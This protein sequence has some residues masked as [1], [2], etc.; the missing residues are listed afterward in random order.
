VPSPFDVIVVGGGIAGLAAAFELQQHGLRVRVF[1]ASDRPGGVIL[2]ERFDGW[3]VDGGP[4]ALL[5]QKPA[6]VAL[7]RE[8]GLGERLHATQTP[9][10]AYV[11]R[12]GRLYP[13]A[14]GSF[15]GFP[16]SA[17]ALARSSL[18]STR[19]KLRMGFEVFVPRRASTTDESIG[20]FVRRRFGQEATDYLADPL[21]AGIH[22]GDKDRLSIQALFPRLVEAERRV[23]SVIR[24]FRDLRVKPSPNGAFVSLPGGI[25]EMVDR[26]VAALTPGTL[27][28]S[29]P[30][31]AIRGGKTF[32]VEAATHAAQATAVILA[33]PA[34]VAASLLRSFDT[35]LAELCDTMPYASTAT[36]AFGYRR[37]QVQHPLSGSGFVVP[38]KERNPLLAGTWVSSKWPHR[39]PRGDV[40]LRGF[41]GGGRDPQRLNYSDPELIETA[42]H[43]LSDVLQISGNPLFTRLYRWTRQSPQYEVGHLERLA[44]IERRLARVPGLYV[45][46]SGFRAIGI[47]DCVADGR[48]TAKTAAAFIASKIATGT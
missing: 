18:F 7:C 3:V 38:Q 42:R 11:L 13:I 46:G 28:T 29:S 47:P 5:V 35:T 22:A 36:V 15:L 16:L 32:T 39:A 34:Y 24:A 25:G 23:G 31:Q 19:G 20:S 14:E 37:E 12:R 45:A 30:V 2:S 8:L 26:L 27:I 10:T 33:V 48:T 40:L 17:K 4:D 43:A 6:A 21:L 1:E 9:R 44:E 41:L